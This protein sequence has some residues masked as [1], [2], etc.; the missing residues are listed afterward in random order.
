M[1]R[2]E[3]FLY[4]TPKT[5]PYYFKAKRGKSDE[6]TSGV[7]KTKKAAKAAAKKYAPN[8]KPSYKIRIIDRRK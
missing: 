1:P 4:G 5:Y 2:K 8:A 6:F 3:K 7:F